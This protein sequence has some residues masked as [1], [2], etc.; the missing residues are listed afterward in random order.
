MRVCMLDTQALH[1]QAACA[2]SSCSMLLPAM[3]ARMLPASC[4]CC[5]CWLLLCCLC[6][7]VAHQLPHM[8]PAPP[9]APRHPP[10]HCLQALR[11]SVGRLGV[12][13]RV[14][15][16]IVHDVPVKRT[17]RTLTPPQF[18]QLL[19]GAS[20]SWA[21]NGTLPSWANESA[22]RHRVSCLHARQRSCCAHA[23]AQRA[24]SRDPSAGACAL[25]PLGP[26]VLQQQRHTLSPLQTLQC[27]T[28]RVLL[29]HPEADI[30]DGQL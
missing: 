19:E 14:Q 27:C 2:G 4:C 29:D 28:R 17:L 24:H 6:W 15:L 3:C 12:I 26:P 22:W 21:A 7:E 25:A 20:A 10:Q 23:A 5:G 1:V 11:V 30:H 9:R 13:A 18:L 8:P 16:R